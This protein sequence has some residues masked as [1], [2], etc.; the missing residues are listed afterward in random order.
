[1][2]DKLQEW[3]I[4]NQLD[5]TDVSFTY[6]DLPNIFEVKD[7]DKQL[8]LL[9]REEIFGNDLR[10]LLTEREKEL[11]EYEHIGYYLFYFGGYFYYHEIQEKLESFNEFRYVGKAKTQ[12][13]SKFS[14]FVPLGVHGKFERMSGNGE[15]ELWCKKAKFFGY[16]SLGICETSLGGLL[17]FRNACEEE[18]IKPIL[19][20]TVNVLAG[21]RGEYKIK[22]FA[23]DLKGYEALI[24]LSNQINIFGEENDF[25]GIAEIQLDQATQNLFVVFDTWSWKMLPDILEYSGLGKRPGQIFFQIDTVCWSDKKIDKEYLNII[26][27]YY[28][29]RYKVLC[30]PI[31]LN[32]SYYLDQDDYKIREL[33]LKIDEVGN[34]K[35]SKDQYFKSLDDSYKI[36]QKLFINKSDLFSFLK[37]CV[38]NTYIINDGCNIDFPAKTFHLPRFSLEKLKERDSTYSEINSNGE[39]F[40]ELL[41]EAMDNRKFSGVYVERLDK[42]VKLIEKGGFVDYFLKTWDIIREAKR[43]EILT[44]LGRGSAVGSLV[45]YLLD[46]TRL[47]PIKYD[48]LFER[49]LNEG[50]MTKTLPD[51]DTDFQSDGRETI[52]HYIE[53]L[54]GQNYVTAVGSYGTLQIKA[55]IKD[56]A[57]M[58][59]LDYKLTNFLTKRM[60][61]NESKTGDW[62]EIFRMAQKDKT[63]MDSIHKNPKL[64]NTLRKILN[65]P[66]SISVH[67]CGIIILPNNYENDIFSW[68]PL[69]IDKEEYISEWGGTDLEK[70]G[71]LKEDILGLNQLDKFKSII[72]L[73]KRNTSENI[74]IYKIPLEDPKVMELFQKGFTADVFQFGSDGLTSYCKAVWPETIMELVTMVAL[75][76]PGP[77]GSNAHIDYIK[78]KYEEKEAEYDFQLKEVTEETYGLYIFQ[79]QVMKA[80]MVLGDFNESETDD[81]RRAMGKKEIKVLKPYKSQFVNKAH[82]KGCEIDEANKIW[83]KL[84]KFSGYGFNKSHSVAYAI[85]GYISNWLK[86]YYPIE[87]WTTAFE[88]IGEDAKGKHVSRYISE[89]NHSDNDIEIVPPDINKSAIKFTSDYNSRRIYW[90]LGKIAQLGPVGLGVILSEREKSGKFYDFD[91]FYKRC[92]DVEEGVDKRQVRHL[93]LAGAFDEIEDISSPEL[94][95][96]LLYYYYGK[97]L[98]DFDRKEIE[99]KPKWWWLLKQR[100]IS[101]LGVI[102]YKYLLHQEGLNISTYIE[103]YEYQSELTIGKVVCLGGVIADIQYRSSKNGDWAQISLDSNNE[104]LTVNMWNDAYE[105]YRDLIREGKGSILLSTGTIDSY[106]EVNILQLGED[107]TVVVLRNTKLSIPS[108]NKGLQIDIRKNNWAKLKIGKTGKITKN[109]SNKCIEVTFIDGTKDIFEKE[110]FESIVENVKEIEQL[111]LVLSENTK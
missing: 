106:N 74:N 61:I 35:K 85:T 29:S 47:D 88:L 92:I 76:R 66:K 9:S 63:I 37:E 27:D 14:N 103:P 70:A 26:K 16:K 11:S 82:E 5:V 52:K 8:L 97:A 73:I 105:Q 64:Y 81:I 18:G 4:E 2:E 99:E 13:D 17:Q 71:F 22:V 7:E 87:F 41:S 110:H 23:Q 72:D 95:K 68:V 49:F 6:T 60:K 107:S 69:R 108:Q 78:L 84:E 77:I 40:R 45:S 59:H 10:F 55:G 50:R 33:L 86:L 56:I 98:L 111:E 19:G 57:R 93:I 46:I 1:M 89:I 12:L 80:C 65:Q 21:D 102:D 39:L 62:D 20:M 28:H 96:R 67:P 51:I 90:S 54:Y 75:F 44:G 42:E 43:L 109:S 24:R 91:E 53:K 83:N 31:L 25:R 3:I 104:S 36:L 48:L 38:E 79:E 34:Y 15:Y 32:D 101:S 94:R 58:F 100:E 30:P